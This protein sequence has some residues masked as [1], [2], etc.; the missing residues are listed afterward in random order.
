M[1]GK[2]YSKYISHEPIRAI[3]TQPDLK[4]QEMFD[5]NGQEWDTACITHYSAIA[6][7]IF[8]LKDAHTHPFPEFVCFIGG[9]PQHVRDFGAE[10][11][12]YMGEEMEEHVITSS[13][14]VYCPPNFP[15]CPLNFKVVRKPIVLMTISLGK[16]YRQDIYHK[17]K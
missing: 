9:D 17:K 5:V 13:S 12:M 14:V 8:L 3:G 1:P 2:K 7:P 10:V 15:H 6:K 16:E 4:G 11:V